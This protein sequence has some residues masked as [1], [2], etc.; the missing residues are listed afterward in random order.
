MIAALQKCV[1]AKLPSNSDY[2]ALSSE[3]TVGL[4]SNL[5]LKVIK[6]FDQPK[7]RAALNG[8]EGGKLAQSIPPLFKTIS[9]AAHSVETCKD[10]KIQ[11][12]RI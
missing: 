6:I 2:K 1:K 8:K 10:L 9:S 4:T 12:F 3:G 5:C 7:P 11:Q